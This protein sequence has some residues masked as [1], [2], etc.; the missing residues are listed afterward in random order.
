MKYYL[1]HTP[2]CTRC[3]EV[4]KYLE[5]VDIEVVMIDGTTDDG[6]EFCI[7]RGVLSAPT[8][9]VVGDD[10]QTI[11]VLRT[12]PGIREYLNKW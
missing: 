2:H 12:L 1:V 5:T 11:E 10:G 4:I 6:R 9:V 8:F 7:D 3:P